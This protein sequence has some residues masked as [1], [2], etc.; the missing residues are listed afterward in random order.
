MQAHYYI[1]MKIT[2]A[3][4]KDALLTHFRYER[5]FTT[6]TEY[7]AISSQDID[8]VVTVRTEFIL[9]E[10]KSIYKTCLIADC[11]EVKISFQD[12]KHDFTKSKHHGKMV[13]N[14]F[15]FVVPPE[16]V[17]KCL[18]Y[19]KDYP[20][21]GLMTFDV[22]ENDY[23]FMSDT[24][25]TKLRYVKRPKRLNHRLDEYQIRSLYNRLS[26]GFAQ[27][28]KFEVERDYYN[29]KCSIMSEK[30]KEFYQTLDNET[31]QRFFD[32]FNDFVMLENKV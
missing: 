31:K 17:D 14:H 23:T 26:S 22:I 7:S 1:K 4:I 3:K 2:S 9:E 15:S 28:V 21:Y 16:I 11:F 32:T 10:Q 27:R 25:I 20:S 24:S 30:I 6:V 13:Y 19:L 29:K 12:F 5:G 8:D 18:E